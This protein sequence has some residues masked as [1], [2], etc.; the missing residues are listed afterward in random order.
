M[1]L[2]CTSAKALFA[3]EGWHMATDQPQPF[4]W[5]CH[6]GD[7]FVLMVRGLLAESVS[8]E[9]AAEPVVLEISLAPPAAVQTALESC[10]AAHNL[11]L[12]PLAAI[13][14]SLEEP[15]TL[16]ACHLPG[17]NLFIF[18]ENATLR[19]QATPGG[20]LRLTVR[21]GFKC[22]KVPCRETDL[23]L[24]LERP[25]AARLLSLAFSLVRQKL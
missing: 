25:G 11:P 2:T 14:E 5:D 17:T 7:T 19:A 15:L 10:A 9:T 3:A 23:L 1:H 20:N 8:G 6:H 12:A 18:S 4:L 13:P 21:G 16:A 24:H 22:R